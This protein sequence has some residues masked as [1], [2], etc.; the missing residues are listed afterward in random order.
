LHIV[1]ATVLR[2]VQCISRTVYTVHLYQ[3]ARSGIHEVATGNWS[4]TRVLLAR[5]YI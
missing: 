3:C 2:T 1:K 5:L 4:I